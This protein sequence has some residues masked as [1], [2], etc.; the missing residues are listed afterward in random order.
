MP[1]PFLN[2]LIMFFKG[3]SLNPES[4]TKKNDAA[5]KRW[6]KYNNLPASDLA[7]LKKVVKGKQEDDQQ[8]SS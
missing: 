5:L 2:F 8:P 6:L 3:F 7:A 1:F 4:F